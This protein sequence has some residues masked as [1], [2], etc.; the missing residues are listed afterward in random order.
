M[1]LLNAEEYAILMN[2][3]RSAAGLTPLAALANPSA[4]ETFDWQDEIFER[5]AMMNHS[6]SFTKGTES[7]STPRRL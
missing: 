5:A 6:F 2:E 1:A 4:L 7:S 3:S